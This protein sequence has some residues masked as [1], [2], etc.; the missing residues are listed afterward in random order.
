MI[1]HSV[2]S[3]GENDGLLFPTSGFVAAC[4]RLTELT[5]I[6]PHPHDSRR[7]ETGTLSDPVGSARSA[8]SELVNAC[9]ALPDFDTLQIVHL[10]LVTPFLI[11][12]CGGLRYGRPSIG[13]REP[14]AEQRKQMSGKRAAKDPVVDCLN[15]KTRC[16]EGE[17]RK[18]ITLR[19]IEL[20]WDYLRPF[21]LDSMKVEEYEA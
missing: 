21:Y 3:Q 18:K 9:K 17:G 8:T 1:R 6:Y 16:Q 10:P 4:P 12:A 5:I 2:G 13:A 14:W 7:S 15:S 19:T 11:C 20:C